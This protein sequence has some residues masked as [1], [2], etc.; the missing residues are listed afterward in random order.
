MTSRL[1]A[2]AG[3]ICVALSTPE[4]HVPYSWSLLVPL[5]D[6][7]GEKFHVKD[8]SGYKRDR[9]LVA[10]LTL[11]VVVKIGQ[12]S[13]S[14]MSTADLDAALQRVPNATETQ[15]WF[16]FALIDLHECGFIEFLNIDKLME[17]LLTLAMVVQQKGVRG[18]HFV[19]MVSK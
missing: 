2:N 9:Q 4:N 3:D 14:G 16:R 6:T 12:L 18:A 17:E 5:S 19:S 8:G 15:S 7:E 1:K 11:L 10:D 13:T